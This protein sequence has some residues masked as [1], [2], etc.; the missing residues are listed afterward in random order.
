MKAVGVYID[1]LLCIWAHYAGLLYSSSMTLAFS[2]FCLL[3][4]VLWVKSHM[5]CFCFGSVDRWLPNSETHHNLPVSNVIMNTRMNTYF[6]Y[7]FICFVSLSKIQL[8]YSWRSST[9][10]CWYCYD[11]FAFLFHQINTFNTIILRSSNI[12][13]QILLSLFQENFGKQ[14]W[15]FAILNNFSQ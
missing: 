15:A 6:Y 7:N 5:W 4:F 14:T 13:C 8:K 2:V 3:L 1:S 9:M 12:W 10:F 11:G